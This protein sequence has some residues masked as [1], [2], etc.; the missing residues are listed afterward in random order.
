MISR[1]VA[2]Y[3]GIITQFLAPNYIRFPQNDQ[4]IHDTKAAFAADYNFPGVLGVI[5]GTHIAITALP[6]DIENAYM[7]RKGF[8]SINVQLVCNSQMIFTNV[9]ARF[10][11]STHDAY[12]YGGSLLKTRL[13]EIHQRDPYNFNHL[14]GKIQIDSL[15]AFDM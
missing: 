6:K 3:S 9:N 4:E 5:D 15:D 8:H 1:Y 13:E 7:N 2:K 14:I 11:G 10:L 12:I